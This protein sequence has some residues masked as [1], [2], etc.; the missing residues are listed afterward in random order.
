MIS[1]RSYSLT[2]GAI[3]WQYMQYSSRMIFGILRLCEG[4]SASVNPT[5]Y[6]VDV[7]NVFS[8][9]GTPFHCT[10]PNIIVDH[11]FESA[12]SRH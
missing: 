7:V 2:P 8:I 11:L 1:G 10:S 9:I 3:E 4:R 12:L 6:S 5:Y